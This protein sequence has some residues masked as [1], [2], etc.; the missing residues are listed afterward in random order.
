MTRTGIVNSNTAGG[1]TFH[2]LLDLIQLPLNSLKS[3][4]EGIDLL[5][6]PGL[7]LHY[8]LG[9]LVIY[10]FDRSQGGETIAIAMHEDLGIL[11]PDIR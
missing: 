3:D 5:L 6:R 7:P 11:L 2:F 10:G 8:L 9:S 1:P 4:I